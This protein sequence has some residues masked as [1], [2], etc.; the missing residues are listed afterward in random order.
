MSTTSTSGSATA[1]AP[2]RGA[3]FDLITA[4][5]P[6]VASPYAQGPSYHAGGATGD[7]VL[8]RIIAGFG[9][10][11]R[12]GGRAFAVSHVTLRTDETLADIAADWFRGFPGRAL[13]VIVEIG[14]PVDLAAAQALFALD[15]GLAAYAAEVQRWLAYLR[16]HRAREVAAILGG[17][18]TRRG[19]WRRGRRRAAARFAAAADGAAGAT[20]CRVAR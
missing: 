6:F 1:Y 11:L 12:P 7:R 10:H 14:S 8:R 13:V 18:G 9:R 5:P 20:D 19:A 17:R 2:V 4:N 16:R 3:Q 15:R